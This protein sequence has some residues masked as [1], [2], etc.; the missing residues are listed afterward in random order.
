MLTWIKSGWK[1]ASWIKEAQYIFLFWSVHVTHLEKSTLKP[2]NIPFLPSL[3]WEWSRKLIGWEQVLGPLAIRLISRNFHIDWVC[4]LVHSWFHPEVKDHSVS[5][6]TVVTGVTVHFT[7]V[8]FDGKR[9][10]SGETEW[11]NLCQQTVSNKLYFLHFGHV[12]KLLLCNVCESVKK[13]Q[14]C[15]C[16]IAVWRLWRCSIILMSYKK[17]FWHFIKI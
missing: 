15:L 11:F 16:L 2:N 3:D 7:M 9:C 1:L 6:V 12:L 10:Y 14:N 5:I 4:V 13:M 8:L 17:V